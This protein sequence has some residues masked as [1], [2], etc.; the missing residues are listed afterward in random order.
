MC[1]RLKGGS[2]C[3][4]HESHVVGLQRDSVAAAVAR[5]IKLPAS[6][7]ISLVISI[8]EGVKTGTAM[9]CRQSSPLQSPVSRPQCFQWQP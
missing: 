6:D 5:S 2:A 9:R 8:G 1:E 3:C 7:S 4:F